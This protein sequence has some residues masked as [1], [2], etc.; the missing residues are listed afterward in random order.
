MI[1]AGQIHA[2]DAGVVAEFPL[3]TTQ[4]RC[5]FLDRMKPGNTS[6]NIAVRWEVR[7][8][9][10][11]ESIERAFQHVIERH[12]ILRTRFVEVDGN[13]VQQVM[14]RAEFKLDLVDI[15][16]VPDDAQMA[17]VDEIVK[18]GASR[19]FDL[20][21]PG[22]IRAVLIRLAAERAILAFTIHQ[23]CFDGFSIKV[24]G[25][26]IGTAAQAFEEGRTPQ[27][28][29]LPLQYGDFTLWQREYMDSGV[30]EA[31]SAW[32]QEQLDGLSYF[33]VEPDLPRPAVRGQGVSEMTLN[34]PEDFGAKLTAAAK[35][36]GVSTYT[37]GA[38]V[39][40]AAM[41]RLTGAQDFA[42]GTQIAGRVDPELDTLI[43]V[44][45]NNLVLR[46]AAEPDASLAGQIDRA[47]VVMEGA[48]SH[49]TMPFNTLVER[50]NP[51]RDPARTPLISVNFN[52][53]T[54]FMESRT[55]GSFDLRSSP[56]HAAGAIYDLSMA[57]MGRP[58]GWQ[59]VLDYSTELFTPETIEAL[60]ELVSDTFRHAFDAP[61]TALKDIPL[62][63]HL[64]ERGLDDRRA[65]AAAER[66]LSAH[67]M[68]R[69]AAVIRAGRTLYGFV[70]PGDTGM[71]PLEALPTRL[72]DAVAGDPACA[73]LTGISVLGGF[74]RTS[75]GGV[76]KTLLNAPRT[77][78]AAARAVTA[79]PDVLAALTADWEEI[80][81]VGGLT[82]ESQFF[83]LGGHS[84]LVLRMLTR[85]R[86]RWGV[87]LDVAQVYEHATLGDLA[88][89]VTRRVGSAEPAAEAAP[90]DSGDWRIIRMRKAGEG[91][92]LIAVNNAATALAMATAGS[93]PRQTSC[94]RIHDHGRD[95]ALTQT[96]FEEIA[97]DYAE[98]VRK[99][100]PEGPYLL[101]GNCVHGNLALE[102]ARHLQRDGAEVS[103][104]MKDVWEPTYAARLNA[105]GSTRW[106]EKLHALGNRIR[107]V[108]EGEMSVAAMLGSY[109]AVRATGVLSLAARLG[110]IDRVRQT[111]L[112]ADQERFIAF[113]TDM[114]NRYRPAPVDFPVLH[115]VT[116]ITP[117][118]RG[119][120]PS[121]GWEGVVADGRLRTV[122]IDK[123]TILRDRRVGV[124]KMARAVERFLGEG[125]SR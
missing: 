9:V 110:L 96:S 17:R 50:L 113:V 91:L 26:E 97:A 47:R 82:A 16:T 119:F 93:A 57:V 30:L 88:R 19:P 22:L 124:E 6:L 109:R 28:P 41:H 29:D 94:V 106:R 69:E 77:P 105:D 1:E 42:F 103:V 84:V 21:R 100:Q 59:M 44:F 79:R 61:D 72:L 65:V 114:R 25:A 4:T 11:A 74:P 115:V 86:D 20:S 85:I 46:F 18:E 7:G 51:P 95:V 66:A 87:Q 112:E 53:Q 111:D 58:A 75:T 80:L 36:R 27:L 63:R 68:V 67:P 78:A 31:E 120:S 117:Q 52:L 12:E 122:H 8:K 118:G 54:V 70:V 101:Y 37:F 76:N 92:P 40:S 34:L 48:L 83:D 45:I 89:L 38:G 64:A 39:F 104:V 49:Q 24:L 123:V 102:T 116:G 73:D 43:G 71:V 125:Q 3:S 108:R 13:P 14:E 5:W 107:A 35:A 32:W 15:R 23:T 121:I 81:S 56:S 60:L 99:A 33:E 10:R 2:G 55:Y 90:E 98:V 62:P